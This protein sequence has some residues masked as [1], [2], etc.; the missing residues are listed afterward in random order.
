MTEPSVT[1]E[2]YGRVYATTREEGDTIDGIPLEHYDETD[3]GYVL[4]VD[5]K[6]SA[7]FRAA[8]V[9]IE[10]ASNRAGPWHTI[11]GPAQDFEPPRLPL[12]MPPARP[13]SAAAFDWQANIRAAAAY[14]RRNYGLI[15]KSWEAYATPRTKEYLVPRNP[16]D[17]RE[18]PLGGLAGVPHVDGESRYPHLGAPRSG[19]VAAALE[20]ADPLGLT[21]EDLNVLIQAK[22]G[23][24]RDDG[25]AIEAVHAEE[26]MLT[27]QR[28]AWTQGFEEGEEDGVQAYWEQVERTVMNRLGAMAASVNEALAT[29]VEKQS[30]AELRDLLERIVGETENLGGFFEGELRPDLFT[31]RRRSTR[32]AGR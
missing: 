27:A 2:K 31:S 14:L 30:R 15:T 23:R 24:A 9:R 6:A 7:A 8:A 22:T 10:E 20:S 32:N 11:F 16:F 5:D 28:S 12:Q 26:R 13:I 3:D 29:P 1:V 4:R 19:S 25:A 17:R 21:L 18:R